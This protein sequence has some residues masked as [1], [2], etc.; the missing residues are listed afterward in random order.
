MVAG[1]IIFAGGVAALL[2]FLVAENASDNVLTVLERPAP[3]HVTAGEK[4]SAVVPTIEEQDYL[5]LLLTSIQNQTY[6]PIETIV[7]DSSPQEAKDATRQVI[8]QFPDTVMVDAPKLNVSHGRNV[9]AQAASGSIL[10]FCDADIVLEHRYAEKLARALYNGAILSHGNEV[11][12]SW[13]F[14]LKSPIVWKF[15]S[16]LYTTGRGVAIRKN[17]FFSLPTGGYDEMCDPFHG[18]CREDKKLARDVAAYYGP[19]S[20]RIV[21]D[22]MVWNSNRRPM[23]EPLW[24]KR[25]WRNGKSIDYYTEVRHEQ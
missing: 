12:E 16:A 23:F 4:V 1:P 5:P 22:A 14:N 18:G 6:C 11:E 7:S 17:D 15:K 9:G 20:V 2:N 10:L 8:S 13:I 3:Y 19:A 21:R 25:G 24:N